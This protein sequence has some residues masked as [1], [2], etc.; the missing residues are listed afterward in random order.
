[1]KDWKQVFK[2]DS[3]HDA[4]L[5]LGRPRYRRTPLDGYTPEVIATVLDIRDHPPAYCPR[6]PG[7]AVIQYELHQRLAGT[8][9]PY[10]R[11]TST[12]WRILDQHQRILRLPARAPEPFERPEPMRHWEIDFTD[13]TSIAPTPDGKQ[14][15][16]AEMFNVV[17][18]GTSIL[19][20]SA[21]ASDYTAETSILALTNVFMAEGL[22]NTIT[23]DRDPRFIGG[24]Q[25]DDFPSAFMR[26]LLALDIH[27]DICP[28]RRPDRKPF[29]ERV[30]RTIQEECLNIE[31]PDNLAD[32][33]VALHHYRLRYN[34]QRPH[35]GLA[36]GNQPP[37]VAFPRLPP[38]RRLPQIIDPDGWVNVL[39][40]RHFRRQ[41]Q[42]N[43]S[44]KIDNRAYYIDKRR[45]GQLVA[46]RVDAAGRQFEVMYGRQLIK[47]VAIKGLYGEP[48]D[49]GDYLDLICAEART[50]WRQT[51]RLVRQRRLA[52]AA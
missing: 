52:W 19:V 5:V 16:A 51:K 39:H 46:L 2:R 11:S 3:G 7:P 4:T 30:H 32:A 23:L 45:P 49:F 12:I 48:V 14:Q 38:L 18:R 6:T 15:H 20:E 41:V 24:W 1:M 37:Y 29:V 22:P 8:G 36:C 13:I 26:F 40:G 35:Q 43:G 42:A 47:R 17:D 9:Q 44:V 50:E 34:R 10:P 33:R 21:A 25:G 31:W 27:L 28:P